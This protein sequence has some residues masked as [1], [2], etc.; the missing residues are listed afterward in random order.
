MSHEINT[1]ESIKIMVTD[2]ATRKILDELIEQFRHLNRGDGI[3]SGE[4]AFVRLTVNGQS[5]TE[6]YDWNRKFGENPVFADDSEIML[7]LNKSDITDF[8]ML[9][10]YCATL[11]CATYG[12]SFLKYLCDMS[13]KSALANL[14]Y[15]V[16]E[17]YDYDKEFTACKLCNG[18]LVYIEPNADIADI[19]NVINWGSADFQLGVSADDD[20]EEAGEKSPHQL[21]SM[22]KEKYNLPDGDFVLWEDALFFHNSFVIEHGSLSE[23]KKDIERFA[24][25]AQEHGFHIILDGVF[26]PFDDEPKFA[27]M[28]FVPGENGVEIVSAKY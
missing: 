4:L 10:E 16:L 27:Y 19:T 17:Y 26:T 13:D 3:Y 9:L 28:Y 6:E 5:D 25:F 24:G 8:E 11:T 23:L 18:E 7:L 21:L 15:K 20:F 1:K 14:E 22:F 2:E 12:Y